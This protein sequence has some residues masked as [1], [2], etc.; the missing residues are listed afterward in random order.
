MFEFWRNYYEF[1]FM[2]FV[3]FRVNLIKLTSTENYMDFILNKE[4]RL[5]DGTFARTRPQ[6]N[7]LW[8]DELNSIVELNDRTNVKKEYS[9]YSE[10]LERLHETVINRGY[11]PI[12]FFVTS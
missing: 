8:L 7:T 10:N 6:H 4:Y 11:A 1:I 12:Y 9:I 3:N 5:A 2:H